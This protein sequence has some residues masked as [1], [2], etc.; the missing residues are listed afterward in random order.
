MGVAGLAAVFAF[1]GSLSALWVTGLATAV[2]VVVCVV[3]TVHPESGETSL[4]SAH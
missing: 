3:E 1:G 4:R 2:L